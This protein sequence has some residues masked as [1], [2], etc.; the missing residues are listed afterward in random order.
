MEHYIFL[1]LNRMSKSC[2]QKCSVCKQSNGY[3]ISIS[4]SFTTSKTRT[5]MLERLELSVCL[6][7]G[8]FLSVGFE[9]LLQFHQLTLLLFSLLESIE[10]LQFHLLLWSS[11]SLFTSSLTVYRNASLLIST[12][13]R[14][15]AISTTRIQTR[16]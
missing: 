12:F 6:Q 4:S 16:S 14:N 13:S 15:Q 8:D 5:M 11:R 10:I 2:N 3:P 1:L 7:L 9:F